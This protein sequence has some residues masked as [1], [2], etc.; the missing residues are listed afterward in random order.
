M[1]DSKIY[2]KTTSEI[3]STLI[4]DVQQAFGEIG[5]MEDAL[6]ES[7][8]DHISEL[9]R[10]DLVYANLFTHA[11]DMLAEKIYSHPVYIEAVEDSDGCKQWIEEH[12]DDAIYSD[13]I[14]DRVKEHARQ[15]FA[16]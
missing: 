7:L 3:V 16:Q 4:A 11:R 14:L 13:N 8:H 10:S 2:G 9:E 6:S 1:T 15:Y 12:L 5:D